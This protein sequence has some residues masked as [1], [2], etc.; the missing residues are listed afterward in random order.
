MSFHSFKPTDDIEILAITGEWPSDDNCYKIK[1]HTIDK[2]KKPVSIDMNYVP[3]TCVDL[4][5]K[6]K[7]IS[8]SPE[9]ML[10]LYPIIEKMWSDAYYS[11]IS[12]EAM[13]NADESL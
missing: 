4:F 5:L 9:Q 8:V 3:K 10:A 7:E 1:L 11:G 6:M 2:D 13:S 12:D